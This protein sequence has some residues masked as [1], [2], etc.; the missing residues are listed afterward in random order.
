LIDV[1]LAYG[2]HLLCSGF[3]TEAGLLSNAKTSAHGSARNARTKAER[4]TSGRL[5]G[6]LDHE[7]SAKAAS[8]VDQEI[9]SDQR[10]AFDPRLDV[11]ISAEFL[12]NGGENCA[13][14]GLIQNGRCSGR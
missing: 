13:A 10:T 5:L 7:P 3:I 4:V 9:H 8:L 6:M 11:L 12:M 2:R 14:P 1:G